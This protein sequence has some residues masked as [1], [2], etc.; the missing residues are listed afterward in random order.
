ML[1][2]EHLDLWHLFIL[3]G[4]VVCWVFN[5]DHTKGT[6]SSLNECGSVEM[7]M[8][9]ECAWHVIL[10]DGVSV[11]VISA[12]W[13]LNKDVVSWIHPADVRAMGVDIGGV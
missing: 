6:S 7:R 9:P 1:R 3:C 8:I 12:W 5:D 2:E 11:G 13:H 10:P 4:Q